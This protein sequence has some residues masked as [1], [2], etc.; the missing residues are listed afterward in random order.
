MTLGFILSRHVN[1]EKTNNYWKECINQIR[2]FYPTNYIIVVD[3]NSN[4]DFI[5]DEN[6]DLTNC[7]FIQSE[8]PQ[9]AELLP[10][11]YFYK[12]KPFDTAVILSD[13]TFIRSKIVDENNTEDIRFI[14]SFNSCVKQ[15]IGLEINLLRNLNHSE[16]L[17]EIYNNDSL[18]KGC[19]SVLSMIRHDFITRL[20]EKYNF[21][22]LL[23]HIKCR[24]DRMCLERVFAVLCHCEDIELVHKHPLCGDIMNPYWRM[25]ERYTYDE[26]IEE[27]Q[28]NK[29]ENY[30]I[31]RVWTGR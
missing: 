26:Y 29:I 10:Y 15:D 31:I 1:S 7:R 6:V 13:S 23:D 8:Y 3:D 4:Y 18:W 16:K 5:D 17:I 2:K 14:W 20:V 28:N 12:L 9:R 30:Q 27:K 25:S 19:F 22:V 11:Y 24:H 21:L